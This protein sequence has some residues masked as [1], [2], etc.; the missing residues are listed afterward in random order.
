M[1][2]MI[3]NNEILKILEEFTIDYHKKVYG[4]GISKKLKINQKTVAN[5]LNKLEREGVLKFSVEGKN[6]YY[7]LN[8]FNPNIKDIMKI[9]EI[10]K[11]I[12]FIEKHKK[13]RD[14]FNK[15]EK[16]TQ[17][18]IV[19][20]GSYAKGSDNEKSDLDI[21]IIGKISNI[22]DLEE[23]YNIKINIIKSDKKKFD[24][25]E[26]II[27]EIIKNHIVLKGIEEFIKLIW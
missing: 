23:L 17:G 4:R 24:K 3:L 5:I 15:L 10:E 20:F 27:G 13:F 2:N 14:L 12:R 19:I 25:K 16:R 21:F 22:E 6:K 11:K 7:F 1:S 8:E 9:I 18:I 26:H